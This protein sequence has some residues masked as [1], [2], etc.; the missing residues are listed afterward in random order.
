MTAISPT[1]SVTSDV[2]TPDAVRSGVPARW[3][4]R[5]SPSMPR[6]SPCTTLPLFFER[7]RTAASLATALATLDAG[8]GFCAVVGG[9]AG[10][11][12]R[13]SSSLQAMA[14]HAATRTTALHVRRGIHISPQ[15]IL[16]GL[17]ATRIRD[18]GTSVGHSE[19][20]TTGISL[21]REPP[22]PHGAL[23][24]TLGTGSWE[25]LGVGRW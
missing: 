2:M 15:I 3:R 17:E 11:S 23:Y 1:S 25:W 12:V 21:K 24:E 10:G 7:N 14:A 8:H 6:G 19:S 13:S 5:T 22:I 20:L 16:P 9:G 18:E 4:Q